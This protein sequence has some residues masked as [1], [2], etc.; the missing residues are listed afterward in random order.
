MNI[1]F[2]KMHG[3][4]N[5]FIVIDDRQTKFPASD[6]AWIGRICSL[7]SGIGSEGL[8]LVQPSK[9]A[10]FFM[11]FFNP[12]G[13]EADMCGNGIRCAARFASDRGITEKKMKIETRAG[14]LCASV[15]RNG[16]RVGMPVPSGIRLNFPLRVEG[17]NITASFINTGVPHAVVE[18][19]EPD[20][21]DL[22]RLGPLL[23]RH[24]AFAPQGANVDYMGITGADSLKVRTYERG[25]EAETPACGTGITACAIIAALTKKVTPPVRVTCR[26]GDTL[27]V[28]FKISGP[29]VENVTLSG[30]AEYVFE[31][32]ITY[33]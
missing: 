16:V 11:R 28:D 4:G 32:E 3:A 2:T 23:R 14:I 9:R 33:P 26:H 22:R 10:A 5:D 30:P 21:V 18:V 1:E 15:M 13:R 20:G 6:R 24:A 27:K 31:G 19:Q 25:V 7:H 8:I 29:G 17:R 12:D